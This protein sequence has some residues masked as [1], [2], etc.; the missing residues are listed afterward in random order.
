MKTQADPIKP[1]DE[2]SGYSVNS[3]QDNERLGEEKRRLH[4]TPRK[5]AE[6]AAMCAPVAPRR[7]G[8]KK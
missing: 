6:F 1:P 5:D 2:F 7:R 3:I 8:K 4:P